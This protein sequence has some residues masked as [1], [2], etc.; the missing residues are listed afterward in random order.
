MKKRQVIIIL[1]IIVFIIILIVIVLL[2]G[3]TSSNFCK[4]IDKSMKNKDSFIVLFE[5]QGYSLDDNEIFNEITNK[6]KIKDYR[7]SI[8]S[9]DDK[10]I[11]KLLD[12]TG[13]NDSIQGND[14]SFSLLYKKGK[15]TGSFLNLSDYSQFEKYLNDNGLIK[16]KKIKEKITLSSFK[17]KI[18]NEYIIIF[19]TKE[20]H[21]K[22]VSKHA[23][24]AFKDVSYNIVNINSD[25]GAKIY[26]Y[27]K[28]KYKIGFFFPMGYYLKDSKMISN[29]EAFDD[30]STYSVFN[31]SIH[32]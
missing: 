5:R 24:V 17:K 29:F 2:F 15:Y 6:Y 19:V 7:I 12:E 20:E 25:E 3:N 4:R 8:S 32:K 30:P 23:S 31:D 22:M 26:N 10:C 14:F 1:S 21:R 16:S 27:M 9:K 11:K 18:E 13:I 28:D